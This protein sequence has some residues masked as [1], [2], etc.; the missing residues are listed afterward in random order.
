[1]PCGENTGMATGEICLPCRATFR[2]LNNVEYLGTSTLHWL[3]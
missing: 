1:M 3:E 2:S